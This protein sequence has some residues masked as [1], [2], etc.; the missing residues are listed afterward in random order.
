MHFNRKPA[1]LFKDIFRSLKY[2][3]FRYFWIGQCISL[4]G[5]WMQ[6]TAQVWLVYSM[7]RSPMMVGLLGVC[8][9]MPMLLFSLVVGVFVDRYP[10]KNILLFTQTVFMLQAVVMTV[11][12]FT[13]M[14]QYWHIFILSAVFGFTQTIDMPARQ[15]FFIEL[16]GKDDLM[17]AISLNSTI[18]NLARIIGP[19]ISGVIMVKYGPV[20]CF[21]INAVSYIAVIGGIFLIK[22]EKGETPGAH[23]SVMDKIADGF[24]YIRR[25]ETLVVNMIVMGAVCTFAMNNDVIIPVF[26]KTVLFRGAAGYTSMLTAAGAGAFLGAIFMAVRSKYGL[27]KGFLIYAAV[28]TS[29]LQVLMVFVKQYNLALLIIAMIGFINLTFI[30]T[31]NGIFQLNS[32]DEYRGRV[33]SVYSF[34][35]QG[36]TPVGN[37]YAGLAMEHLGGNAGFVAC[38][39]AALVILF[40]LFLLKQKTIRGW[41]KNKKSIRE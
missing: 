36:S 7:T 20:F 6:R 23:F 8:Q 11:L 33:M 1:N 14:I 3:N 19:A 32:S 22:V 21:F 13:G 29:L 38:G 17:N 30:N 37:F 18:V 40:P 9:F 4:A 27:H 16:V 28:A 31:A 5:T 34:L 26:A 35:N 12:T 24:R 41:I 15:S 25:S 10:K 39:G 2:P